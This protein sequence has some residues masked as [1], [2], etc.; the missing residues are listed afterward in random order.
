MRFTPAEDFVASISLHFT[1][2][3]SRQ[4]GAAEHEN[5]RVEKFVLAE[6]ERLIGAEIE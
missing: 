4:F 1:D 5:G 6:D 2:G 3:F